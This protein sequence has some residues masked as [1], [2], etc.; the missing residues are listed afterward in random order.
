MQRTAVIT[1][2]GRGLGYFTAER[3]AEAGWRVILTTRSAADGDRAMASIRERVP[4]ARSHR[5]ELDLGSLASVERA[6]DE[7]AAYAPIHALVNNGGDT[8]Q[9]RRRQTTVDG[10]ERTVGVNAWGPFSLTARLFPS[11]AP[12][13]RIVWLG[14]LSTRLVAPDL[15]DLEA[16]RRRYSAFHQYGTSK[17]LQHA[18]ALELDRRLRSSGSGMRSVL[19]HPGYALDAGAASRPGITDRGSTGQRIVETL[20]RPVTQGKDR[21]ADPTVHAVL[22]EEVAGGDF[23]GPAGTLKGRPTRLKPNPRSASPEFGAAAWAAA[24]AATGVEFPVE[25]QGRIGPRGRVE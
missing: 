7:I 16:Q 25:P 19:V 17:H 6:A 20:M 12:N 23:W 4:G 18:F 21:G 8:S 9:P 22:G 1:G 2:A 13:A 11:L 5:V 15:D 24:E 3:L 10:F 14:S